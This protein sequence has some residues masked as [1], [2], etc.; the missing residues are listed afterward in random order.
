MEK[1]S[2]K[3]LLPLKASEHCAFIMRIGEL[4]AGTIAVAAEFHM[5]TTAIPL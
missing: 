2:R 5:F 4:C 1:R 3:K